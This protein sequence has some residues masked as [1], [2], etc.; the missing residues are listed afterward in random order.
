M[1]FAGNAMVMNDSAQDFSDELNKILYDI[2]AKGLFSE[3]HYK[4][5]AVGSRLIHAALI[6]CRKK[7]DLNDEQ[8]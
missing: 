3:V 1:K 6:I 4:P 7:E 8:A 2:Q 5:V